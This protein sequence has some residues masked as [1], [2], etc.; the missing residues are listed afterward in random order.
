MIEP[1]NI[2]IVIQTLNELSCWLE[3]SKQNQDDIKKIIAELESPDIDELKLHQL[4]IKL[5]RKILFHPKCLG[6]VYVPNFVGD[7][8]PYAWSNY[9]SR[10]ADICERNL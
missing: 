1:R 6:E 9:L 2:N 4:R 5:S 10:V 3:C 7:G 8:T